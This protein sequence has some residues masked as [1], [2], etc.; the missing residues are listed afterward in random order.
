[1]VLARKQGFASPHESLAR[2]V[3][4]GPPLR[5]VDNPGQIVTPAVPEFTP[6]R[7]IKIFAFCAA[8]TLLICMGAYDFLNYLKDRH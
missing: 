2:I 4:M 6:N 3:G 7:F 5:T 8:L 1:M